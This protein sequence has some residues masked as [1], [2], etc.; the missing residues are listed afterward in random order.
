MSDS[1]GKYSSSA[2]SQRALAQL[3]S[4]LKRKLEAAAD[5][6][7]KYHSNWQTVNLNDFVDKFAPG[8]TAKINGPKIVFQTPGSNI[9]VVCD[10]RGG[11]CRL[12]DTTNKTTHNY[13]DINGKFVPF[14][15]ILP[16][17][18]QTGRP[19]AEYQ[20]MTHFKIL[21]REEM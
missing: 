13:L 17:G 6:T 15:K 1:K 4:S 21:K 14:N 16:S 3:D 9:E 19:K 2:A 8:S 18:K 10:V 20:S 5:R 11:Y 7:A 12:L